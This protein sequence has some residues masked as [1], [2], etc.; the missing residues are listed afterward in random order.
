M[1]K[2]RRDSF[3]P[4]SCRPA[5][6]KGRRHDTPDPQTGRRRGRAM[7]LFSWLRGQHPTAANLRMEIFALGGRHMGDPLKGALDELRAPGLTLQRTRLLQAVVRQLKN[8]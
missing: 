1:A 5:P 3:A 8:A 4:L 2:A 7:S 6:W